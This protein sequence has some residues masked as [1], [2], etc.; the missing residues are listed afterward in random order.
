MQQVAT[1]LA[2]LGWRTDKIDNWRDC[3]WSVSCHRDVAGLEISMAEL[4]PGEWMLQI[5]PLKY[6]GFITRTFGSQPS[7]TP[8]E[9]Y[10]LAL[11]VHRTLGAAHHYENPRWCWDGYPDDGQSTPEPQPP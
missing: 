6:P 9:V 2:A 4:Q 8:S 7:A 3:G 11:D 5:A 10:Q 1:D